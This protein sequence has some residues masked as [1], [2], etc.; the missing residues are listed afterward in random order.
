[1]NK[2]QTFK[3]DNINDIIKLLKFRGISKLKKK[4]FIYNVIAESDDWD[5]TKARSISELKKRQSINDVVM[6]S[7]GWNLTEAEKIGI[8]LI[9]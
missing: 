6:E 9:K 1:M 3:F 4:Q 7:G 8:E 2:K 5:L